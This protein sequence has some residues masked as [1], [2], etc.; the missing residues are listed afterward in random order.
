MKRHTPNRLLYLILA[1]ALCAPAAQITPTGASGTGTFTNSPGL[2]IDNVIVAEFTDWQ[3][4]PN[5]NN[6]NSRTVWWETT[7]PNF[8]IDLGAVYTVQDA[9]I[10]IDNNDRYLVEYSLNNSSYNTL[11]TVLEA[12]GFDGNVFGGMDTMS[13]VLGNPQYVVGIDFAPV[14]ARYIRLSATAGD[15]KYSSSELQLFG[16]SGVPE[17]SSVALVGLG[18]AALALRSRRRTP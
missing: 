14:Q 12:Y 8:V 17:P 15:N 3:D 6:A 13:T 2:L 1:S 11:F 4:S 5:L 16:V 18:V 7:P 10:S 9:L